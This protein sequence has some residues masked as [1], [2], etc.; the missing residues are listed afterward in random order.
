MD[1]TLTLLSAVEGVEKE[2][3][4]A[5][6]KRVCSDC[7]QLLENYQQ[8]RYNDWCMKV[9][10]ILSQN[11]TRT[12]LIPKG[13]E[14]EGTK[15]YK[16]Y[17]VNF[18]SD[19]SD[20]LAEVKYLESQGFSV[21]D[22]ARNMSIQESKF[23][24]IADDL[25][26]LMSLYESTLDLLKDAEMDLMCRD[27]DKT[28]EVLWPGENRITWNHQGIQEFLSASNNQLAIL[29]SR[30]I[31]VNLVRDEMTDILHDISQVELLGYVSHFI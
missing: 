19:L 24:G 17:E 23:L 15:R 12:L 30:I 31:Q 13:E 21:P 2:E 28:Q 4:W 9:S 16:Q 20:T 29:R 27:I 25:K 7:R 22:V 3:K 8:A 1:Q 11:L 26:S 6:S 10:D 18:T 14:G 5:E